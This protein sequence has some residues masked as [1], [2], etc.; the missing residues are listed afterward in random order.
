MSKRGL[1]IVITL[2]IMRSLTTT[3][4]AAPTSITTFNDTITVHSVIRTGDIDAEQDFDQAEIDKALEMSDEH[5]PVSGTAYLYYCTDAPVTVTLN[6]AEDGSKA[7]SWYVCYYLDIP[8]EPTVGVT[9]YDMEAFDPTTGNSE[10]AKAYSGTI[11]ITKPGTYYIYAINRSLAPEERDIGIY[12]VVGDTPLPTPTPSP[13]PSTP[14]IITDK[15]L[16]EAGN[17]RNLAW[18]VIPVAIVAIVAVA[19]LAIKRK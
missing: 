15:A 12:I 4:F 1:P 5:R 13:T 7:I 9:E 17:S 18:L 11:T 6:K 3:A 16:D 19:I 14:K 8:S 2:L 10:A